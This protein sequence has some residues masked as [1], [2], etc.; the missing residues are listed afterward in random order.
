[1]VATNGETARGQGTI[2]KANFSEIYR[3]NVLGIERLMQW[4][5]VP[6]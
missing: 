4:L 1:M 5:E 3:Y 6:L 2:G